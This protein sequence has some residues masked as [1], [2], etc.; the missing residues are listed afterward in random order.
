MATRERTVESVSIALDPKDTR[1]FVATLVTQAGTYVKEF[2]HSD[3]GRTS[4]SLATLIGDCKLDI[5]QLD[6]MVSSP[7]DVSAYPIF[8]HSFCHQ[9]V[10]TDWPPTVT[11]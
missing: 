6:V 11:R 10:F 9:D 3:F 5:M 1:F 4:P 8:C 7:S 2:V